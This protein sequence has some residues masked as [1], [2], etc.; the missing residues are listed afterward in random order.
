MSLFPSK[1]VNISMDVG[2]G[3]SSSRGLNEEVKKMREEWMNKEEEHIKAV[4]LV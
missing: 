2:N 3:Y 4:E 1:S